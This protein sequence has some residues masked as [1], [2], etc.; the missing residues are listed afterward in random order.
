M[1]FFPPVQFAVLEMLL[2]TAALAA[3][4]EPDTGT[5]ASVLPLTT[6][7]V[8]QTQYLSLPPAT[9]VQMSTVQV[10]KT[11]NSNIAHWE[12]YMYYRALLD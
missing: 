9:N 8:S 4:L 2:P 5:S 11:A 10:H 1:I 3:H 6:D 12:N 7:P